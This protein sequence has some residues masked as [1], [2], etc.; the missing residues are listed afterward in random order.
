M[1]NGLRVF[2]GAIPPAL[3]ES[4]CAAIRANADKF[5]LWERA[6]TVELDAWCDAFLRAQGIAFHGPSE[7]VVFNRPP[8]DSMR[9]HDDSHGNKTANPRAFVCC[10][11]TPTTAG[12]GALKI[13]PGSHLGTHE[14]FRVRC[15]EARRLLAS[16]HPCGIGEYRDVFEGHPDESLVEVPERTVVV[17]DERVIHAV[18]ENV[19][20]DTRAMA[21]RWIWL[22]E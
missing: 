12:R 3:S 1:I 4:C 21:L 22:G 6:H 18:A 13:I 17:A 8:G 11:F 7:W 14:P 9:W 20:L 19:S 15:D 10:Y 2:E 5:F 16:G